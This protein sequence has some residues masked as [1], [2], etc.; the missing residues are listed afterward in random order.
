M[1]PD[2]SQQDIAYVTATFRTQT[3]AERHAA[4][5]GLAPQPSY[6]LPD[7]RG[8]VPASP[9]P[10]LAQASDP[11]DLHRR[12]LTRWIAGGGD[13]ENADS[14]LT[15]WLNGGYGVCLRSPAPE[16]ILA[17]AGLAQAITALV[18]R[19]L[20]Q[21]DWWR[22][23]LRNAVAAY[24]QLVLPFTSVDPARFGG[25]TSRTR[26]VDAVRAQWPDVFTD[27]QLHPWAKQLAKD[28]ER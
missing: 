5:A 7:G 17:K 10:D 14:E 6:V 27:P 11:G 18:A 15:A 28:V 1:H 22:A 21:Q 13:P 24:D 4:A 16:S 19:P 9:D 23:T 25:S 3:D 8:M 20:P 12:F 26:L 2:L